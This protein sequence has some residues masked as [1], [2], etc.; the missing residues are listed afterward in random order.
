MPNPSAA[1]KKAYKLERIFDAISY[2]DEHGENDVPSIEDC[3]ELREHLQ[4]I[5]DVN[6]TEAK[7]ASQAATREKEIAR[8]KANK[9]KLSNIVLNIAEKEKD[10][11]KALDKITAAIDAFKKTHPDCDSNIN[12]NIDLFEP[13]PS[14]RARRKRRRRRNSQSPPTPIETHE[15]KGMDVIILDT[16]SEEEECET[17]DEIEIVSHVRVET[18]PRLALNESTGNREVV[19]E[20]EAQIVGHKRGVRAL[21]DLAHPRPLCAVHPFGD[22]MEVAIKYCDNCFCVRCQQKAQFCKHWLSHSRLRVG[23]AQSVD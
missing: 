3:E 10:V 17:E 15:A 23:L 22:D 5:V 2:T 1:T 14:P 4:V 12:I 21:E 11:N 9:A 8:V 19:E 18:K 13:S 6:E 16:N 7:V 20:D